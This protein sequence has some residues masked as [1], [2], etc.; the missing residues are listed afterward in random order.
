MTLIF[1]SKKNMLYATDAGHG[2]T[3]ARKQKAAAPPVA[4][5]EANTQPREWQP[6]R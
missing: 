1:D 2:F 3:I 4:A 6:L 5:R